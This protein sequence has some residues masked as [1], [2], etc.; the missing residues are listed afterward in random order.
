MKA[1]HLVLLLLG[2]QR[3]C[4][5]PEFDR[6]RK[7]YDELIEPP[8]AKVCRRNILALG[9]TVVLAGAAG[10][11]PRDLNIFGM[12]PSDDWGIIIFCSAAI[13]VHIYWHVLRYFH[14][15]NGGR[16]YLVSS[17]D[18]G[19]VGHRKA[20]WPTDTIALRSAD[21]ISNMAALALTG[22]SWAVIVGLWMTG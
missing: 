12:K 6:R 10:L 15:K 21:R 20:E 5:P 11:D 8:E 16:I 3:V 2:L 7:L 22:L 18:G 13:L 19:T 1:R 14:V 9:G 4:P 17:E